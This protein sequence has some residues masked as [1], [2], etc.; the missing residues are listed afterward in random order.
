MA[1]ERHHLGEA[2]V[3]GEFLAPGFALVRHKVLTADKHGCKRMQMALGLQSASMAAAAAG[4]NRLQ[5]S[6]AEAE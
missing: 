1:L 6:F 3:I 2:L 5:L 4:F